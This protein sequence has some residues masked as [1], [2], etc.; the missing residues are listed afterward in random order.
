MPQQRQTS[1]EEQ[2]L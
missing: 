2:S 1:K